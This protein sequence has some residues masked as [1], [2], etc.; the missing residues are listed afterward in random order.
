MLDLKC[1]IVVTLVEFLFGENLSSF[2]Q[3]DFLYKVYLFICY[4]KQATNT[5]IDRKNLN[6]IKHIVQVI[7]TTISLRVIQ[8]LMS[9][10]TRI[11][12]SGDRLLH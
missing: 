11:H 2:F 5:G 1:M 4:S 7:Y 10:S 8:N 6:H 12:F 3:N 9:F